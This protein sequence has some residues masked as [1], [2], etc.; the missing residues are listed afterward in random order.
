MYCKLYIIYINIVY[1]GTYVITI[2]YIKHTNLNFKTYLV[3]KAYL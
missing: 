1:S 3:L 2:Y